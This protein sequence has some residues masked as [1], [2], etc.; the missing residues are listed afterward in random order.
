MLHSDIDPEPSKH[1]IHLIPGQPTTAIWVE[2]DEDLLDGG[3]SGQFV[4][5]VEVRETFGEGWLETR[6][7]PFDEGGCWEFGTVGWEVGFVVL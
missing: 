7:E 2:L 4:R 3:L 6:S 5:E 1:I